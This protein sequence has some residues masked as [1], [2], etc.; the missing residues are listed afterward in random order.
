[1][2][3]IQLTREQKGL[4]AVYGGV[5][6]DV[7][8]LT[9]AIPVFAP[10]SI[11]LGAEARDVGLLFSV[12]TAG[13][14]IASIFVGKFSAKFGRKMVFVVTSFGTAGSF[15]GAA[16]AQN[17]TQLVIWRAIGGLSSGTIPTS[18]S[19]VAAVVPPKDRPTYMAYLASTMSTCFIIGPLIGGGLAM[20]GM[21]V[22]FFASF[23]FALIS[24]FNAVFFI[25]DVDNLKNEKGATDEEKE[26]LVEKEA[27]SSDK[28]AGEETQIAVKSLEDGKEKDKKADE[29]M[30]EKKDELPPPLS[31]WRNWKALTV[32]ACGVFLNSLCYISYAVLVP[33]WLQQPKFDLVA[34]IDNITDAESKNLTLHF[35]YLMGLFGAMQVIAMTF[36]F[37][38]LIKKTGLVFGAAIGTAGVGICIACIP[39]TSTFTD[40]IPIT[41]F[42]AIANGLV[43]PAFPAFLSSVADK[44]NQTEYVA[45]QSIFMNMA[46][47]IGGQLTVV[48]SFNKSAA[49]LSA[50]SCNLF[51]TIILAIAGYIL[52]KESAS[53][54]ALE[55]LEDGETSGADDVDIELATKGDTDGDASAKYGRGARSRAS[56]VKLE[57]FFGVDTADSE[58][59]YFSD[60]VDNIKAD[61]IKKNL[62]RGVKTSK[63]Q[64]V[65]NQIILDA[66]PTAPE[67]FNERLEWLY[68]LYVQY[69]HEDWGMELS[70]MAHLKHA[71]ELGD[72]AIPGRA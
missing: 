6:T 61:L 5:A 25:T 56:M 42:I 17:F 33:I 23:C 14:M 8:G 62:H 49:F 32:G 27:S 7:F 19:Y 50:A 38:R 55:K 67:D 39:L 51:N 15:L 4:L 26:K 10:Y 58:E 18:F 57:N 28:D 11:Y 30:E 31:P 29:G 3:F 70:E 53:K 12:A 35:S 44:R 47:V 21:R 54:E 60:L 37:P 71:N 64:T 66:L 40:L 9:M 63:G 45:L 13:S 41:I 46:L 24:A 36:G 52:Y 48:Y 20:F 2:V 16:L 22:P 69:G 43:R 59:K 72:F 1:M 65:I 34:D 68:Q